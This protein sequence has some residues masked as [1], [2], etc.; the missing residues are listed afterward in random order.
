MDPAIGRTEP[1]P[2]HLTVCGGRGVLQLWCSH[3]EPTVLLLVLPPVVV[4]EQGGAG[5][6]HSQVS[7]DVAVARGGRG[8]GGPAAQGSGLAAHAAGSAADAAERDGPD[9]QRQLQD[10]LL[11]AGDV[12]VDLGGGGD[13]SSACFILIRL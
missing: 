1:K 6:A 2:S 13:L 10:Q 5:A 11:A 3:E 9:D 7:V 4:V 12:Q 8:E